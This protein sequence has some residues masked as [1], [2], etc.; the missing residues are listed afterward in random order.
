MSADMCV[1]ALALPTGQQLDWDVAE[2][3]IRDLPDT[4]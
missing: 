4:R 2:S 1:A 3:A